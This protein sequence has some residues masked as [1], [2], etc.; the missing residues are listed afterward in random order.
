M[1]VNTLNRINILHF[2]AGEAHSIVGGG[3]DQLLAEGED[4]A[5]GGLLS[6]HL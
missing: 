1:Y 6:G 4:Q 5:L 3:L 2:E